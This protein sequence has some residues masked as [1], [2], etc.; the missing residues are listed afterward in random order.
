MDY[1][2]VAP[3]TPFFQWQIALLVESFRMH[4]LEESL[5]VLL[6]AG[7]EKPVQS[8]YCLSFVGHPRL[9]AVRLTSDS[10]PDIQRLHGITHAVSTGLVSQTFALLPPH[11]VFR[12]PFDKPQA[13]ITFTCKSDFTFPQL[14]SFG[15]SS[16]ALSMRLGEKPVW[17]P[18]GEVFFFD[19]LMPEFFNIAAMRGEMIAFDSYRESYK[20]GKGVSPKG[21]FRAAMAMAIMEAHGRVTLDTSKRLECHMNEHDNVSNIVNYYYGSPPNFSR[22][23]YPTD[24]T[25]VTFS[26]DPF[27]GIMRS[28]DS[29]A[30]NYMKNVAVRLRPQLL[31]EI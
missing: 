23:F 11:C 3:H 4:G 14:N 28:E 5:A 30:A 18:V 20:E 16:K 8:N 29:A 24:G 19:G 12:Y 31:A 13:N 27:R 26:E 15:I 17:L 1:L 10:E 7:S 22:A 2:V 25:G 9:R 21:L 6:I